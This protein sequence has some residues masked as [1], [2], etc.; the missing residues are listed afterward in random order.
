MEEERLK[1]E[2]AKTLCQIENQCWA[3]IMERTRVSYLK[4]A[5]RILAIKGIR[6]ESD[7]QGLPDIPD[8]YADYQ[9]GYET[10][11]QDMLKAGFVKCLPKKE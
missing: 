6:I 9:I 1:E 4:D 11:Q 7:D 8:R 5:D 3:E 10:A 2:I